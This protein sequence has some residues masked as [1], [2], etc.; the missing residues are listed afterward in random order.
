MTRT[1]DLD[2]LARHGVLSPLDVAFARTAARLA[3]EH[4]AHVLAAAALAS[5]QVRHGHVCL[6]L[7]ALDA[8]DL[9]ADRFERGAV[10]PAFEWEPPPARDVERALARSALVG[11]AGPGETPL[12]LDDRRRLYLRRYWEHEQAV[13]HALLAR[14]GAEEA[15]DPDE[16]ARGLA[17]LFG[18]DTAD[19][20]RDAARMAV[21]RRLAVISGGPGTGKTS[22]VVKILALLL[23][24]R[25]P[26]R[27]HLMAPTGKAA[28]RL[29]ESIRAAKAKLAVAEELRARIPENAT[30]IHRA[31]GTIRDRSTRFRHDAS[32]P[33]STDLVLVDEA[34][35]IDLA[36]FRRLLDALPESAR[37]I[38]LGDENQLASVEAGAVLGDVCG[39]GAG[40][41]DEPPAPSGRKTRG[42]RPRGQLSL[43]DAAGTD[44]PTLSPM[45]ACIARL[46]RSY[47]YG[48]ESGI[49]ALARAIH[50]GDGGAAVAVLRDARYAD[51][52]LVAPPSTDALGEALEAEVIEG[53]GTY[54]REKGAVDRLSAFDAFRVLCAHR[55]GPFGVETISERIEKALRAA[56]LVPEGA[57]R[58]YAGRP[59]LI[60]HNDYEVGL[61][62]GDVGLIEQSDD[63][64]GLRAW[65]VSP[66]GTARTLSTA[67]IPAHETVFAMT[68]HKSQG[69]EMDHVAVVL[70]AEPSPVL[71]REL[72]Y[73]AVTRARRRVTVH[74]TEAIVEATVRARI[75]RAS[76]LRDALWG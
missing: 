19:P 69:S 64:A 43:F 35:M 7:R 75:T 3:E 29:T 15:T 32:R 71:T 37:L 16:L 27:V 65:F 33:L 36:L 63:G 56:G 9:R 50:S 44:A 46:A 28:A 66:D 54:L 34:S 72:L 31:L 62:N 58:E 21:K 11:S 55:R 57:G 22:T 73:T 47:R 74:A 10:L 30:T 13:A 59:I 49:G 12:V 45:S 53:Y 61:F 67:R 24:Q 38:L 4:D 39:V 18:T 48:T 23:A 2:E 8:L 68:V 70:P 60:T 40:I 76:G 6:D 17:A 14:A 1:L 51:V 5:R 25:D 26:F 52:S 20:Q 41:A 42:K